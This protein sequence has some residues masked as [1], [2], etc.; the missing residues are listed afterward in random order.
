HRVSPFD[1][2]LA[3]REFERIMREEGLHGL[4]VN[5]M[6]ERIPASDRRYYPPWLAS[7]LR[8]WANATSR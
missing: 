4:M 1:G 5:P 8:P 7:P 6:E 2:V 3:I